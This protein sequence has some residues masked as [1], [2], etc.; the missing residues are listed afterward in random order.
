M[1]SSFDIDWHRPSNGDCDFST[2]CDRIIEYAE[3]MCA[4]W[5]KSSVDVRI[6]VIDIF[7]TLFAV[8]PPYAKLSPGKQNKIVKPLDSISS[9]LLH[10]DDVNYSEATEPRSSHRAH[11]FIRR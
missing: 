5:T 6:N 4:E 10:C 7:V 9:L 1:H 2:E 11:N 3:Q 8:E